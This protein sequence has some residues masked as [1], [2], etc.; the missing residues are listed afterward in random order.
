MEIDA[1]FVG[2]FGCGCRVLMVLKRPVVRLS[3]R[4]S[5]WKVVLVVSVRMR[6]IGAS[7]V[8]S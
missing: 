5:D 6:W 4:S 1:I 2:G 3:C 7:E 8:G